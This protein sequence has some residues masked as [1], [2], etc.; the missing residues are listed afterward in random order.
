MKRNIMDVQAGDTIHFKK[1]SL[2]VDSI[3]KCSGSVIVRGNYVDLEG[4]RVVKNFMARTVEIS[5][6]DGNAA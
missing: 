1:Y 6:P 3:V 2:Y 5:R 4:V